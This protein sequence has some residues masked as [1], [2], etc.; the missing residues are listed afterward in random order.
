MYRSRSNPETEVECCKIY[1][2]LTRMQG[3]RQSVFGNDV[4]DV[5]IEMTLCQN[6]HE[7][8]FL[9]SALQRTRCPFDATPER[10]VLEGP[11]EQ[12]FVPNACKDL[13]IRDRLPAYRVSKLP[14][15]K[16]KWATTNQ[17]HLK[18]ALPCAYSRH[19]RGKKSSVMW[20]CMALCVN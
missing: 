7:P 8:A 13:V 20:I 16:P 9:P 11:A 1:R 4:T 19:S 2:L 10:Y 18:R 3:C 6:A 17:R 12:R 15:V 5:M 14:S